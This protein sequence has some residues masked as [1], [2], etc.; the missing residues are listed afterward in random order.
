MRWQQTLTEKAQGFGGRIV[1]SSLAS[2]TAVFGLPQT[3]EQM[4]Q[5]AVQTALAIR[6][7]LAEDRAADGRQPGPEVR[8]AIHLGQVLVDA[9]ASDPTAHLLPLGET[10]SLPVRLLGQG[11]PGDLLLSPQIGRLVE[12]WFE[13]RRREGPAGVGI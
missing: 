3:L 12:G 9:Q 10:L 4:L 1:Q 7:R 6:H 5:R 11:A 13:L 8:M 2:L